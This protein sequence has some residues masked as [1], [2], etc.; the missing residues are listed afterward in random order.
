MSETRWESPAEDAAEQDAPVAPDEPERP[1]PARLERLEVDP[2]D[3]WEQEEE[4]PLDEDE[5]R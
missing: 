3:A 4:V 5:R 2:A 1:R